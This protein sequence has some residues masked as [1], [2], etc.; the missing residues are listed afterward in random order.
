MFPLP[1]FSAAK[2]IAMGVGALVLVAAFFWIKDAFDDRAELRAWQDSIVTVVR[3][4]APVERRKSVTAKTAGDEIHWLGREYRTTSSALQSQSDK[5]RVAEQ[6]IVGAQDRATEAAK[7]ALGS[8][9]PRKAV[10]D[11]LTAPTRSSGLTEAEWE[12]L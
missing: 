9:K 12:Q 6:K 1:A 11:S 3:S 2:L 5:L 8:D 10:R 7:R 4:E